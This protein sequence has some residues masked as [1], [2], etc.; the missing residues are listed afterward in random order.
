[1]KYIF[2][3][4]LSLT[5]IAISAQQQ[6]ENSGFENWEDAGTV[7][8]EPVDWSSIKTADALGVLAPQVW[9]QSTDAHSGSY[10]VRLENISSFGIVANG[11]IT[12]GRIHADLDPE[13]GYVFTDAGDVQWNSSFTDRPDSLVGWYK[14]TPSG[15]DAGKAQVVLHTGAGQNPENGTL[16]NWVGEARFDF[17][18]TTSTWT[19]FSVPFI[20]YNA[21]T[22]AYL[23]AVLVAGDSTVSVNGSVAL[24]DDLE[25]IYN[26]S[27]INE[28]DNEIAN[29]FVSNNY[30]NINFNND[31]NETSMARIVDLSGRIVWEQKIK[32]VSTYKKQLPVNAGMY[33]F[34]LTTD[35]GFLTKKILIK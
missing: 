18:G 27:S 30:L 21:N 2:T 4:L 3:A 20:Y 24:F 19:R 12:T 35:K 8:D 13:N 28:V 29:V 32:G 9:S 6:I 10:S 34:T 14:Y 25:L 31:V 16:A 33:V 17:S 5:F 26:P 11:I 22:P 15:S 7:V 23:L 1:M